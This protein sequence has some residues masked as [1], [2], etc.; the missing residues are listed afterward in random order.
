MAITPTSPNFFHPP[1]GQESLYGYRFDCKATGESFIYLKDFGFG[2]E[3]AAQLVRNVATEPFRPVK[4]KE[5][6]ILEKMQTWPDMPGVPRYLS[7]CYSHEYIKVKETRFRGVGPLYRSVG[8]WRLCNG[9]SIFD[10]TDFDSSADRDNYATLL[11]LVG[12]ARYVWQIVGTLHFLGHGNPEGIPLTHRDCHPGNIFIHWND[13]DTL[14]PDF[15]LGDFGNSAFQDPKKPIGGEL[16]LRDPLITKDIDH[17]GNNIEQILRR[18]GILDMRTSKVT[19]QLQTARP[20]LRK[21]NDIYWA[22]RALADVDSHE[23]RLE[24]YPDLMHIV[25]LGK[26][27]ESMCLEDAELM[28]EQIWKRFITVRRDAALTRSRTLPFTIRGTLEQALKPIN[29]K[30]ERDLVLYE[31]W[32]LCVLGWKSVQGNPIPPTDPR[33]QTDHALNITA[34]YATPLIFEI[35]PEIE[36]DPSRPVHGDDRGKQPEGKKSG[37]KRLL[38]GLLSSPREKFRFSLGPRL[39]SQAA[40]VGSED[41]IPIHKLDCLVQPQEE[42]KTITTEPQPEADEDT[43]SELAEMSD[44]LAT[45]QADLN[46]LKGVEAIQRR[47]HNLVHPEDC[48]CEDW[49]LEMEDRIALMS[50]AYPT[51]QQHEIKDSPPGHI[52]N[53]DPAFRAVEWPGTL[54]LYTGRNPELTSASSTVVAGPRLRASAA[55]QQQQPTGSRILRALS[56]SQASGSASG[57]NF[58]RQPST[59]PPENDTPSKLPVPR[60][61]RRS[62]GYN[63]PGGEPHWGTKDVEYNTYSTDNVVITS[64]RTLRITPTFDPNSHTWFSSRIE[65]TAPNDFACAPGQQ[66]LIQGS[67]LLRS[68]SLPNQQLSIWPAF[69]LI[70]SGFRDN[71]RG[72]PSVGEVDILETV[73]GYSR[74]WNTVHCGV[75]PGGPCHEKF[76][77]GNQGNTPLT[78]DEWHIVGVR[79]DRTNPDGDWRGETITW[80]TDHVDTYTMKAASINDEAGWKAIIR[81]SKYFILDVAVGGEMPDGLSGLHTP[82]K[83]TKSGVDASM[84]VEWIGVWST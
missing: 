51:S 73:N 66:L 79:I 31:P 8:M 34:W 49:T 74:N 16:W 22:I 13:D 7:E 19:D 5:I 25:Q 1:A 83:D 59:S 46:K 20:A 69:W 70:G 37:G 72:W 48:Q 71:P 52:S 32:T 14:L 24:A 39:Q 33:Y 65:S 18:I 42:K 6:E 55:T 2:K 62:L 53:K 38:D 76:G 68:G 43:E 10:A 47:L 45:L 17:V 75:S 50:S 57:A 9:G 84:E 63:Y 54:R 64:N 56:Q 3:S 80:M 29:P 11:P 15:I 67:I 21:L 81:N 60:K 82:T 61:I 26:E 40:G 12:W 30:T 23:S 44:M 27:M 78:R 4:P 58:K 41:F 28:E 36:E 77:V 35:L